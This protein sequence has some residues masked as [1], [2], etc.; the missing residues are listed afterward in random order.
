MKR[1]AA[2]TNQT[3]L[4]E[5]WLSNK[6]IK[7][8]AVSIPK[9]VKADAATKAGDEQP[10]ADT[11]TKLTTLPDGVARG[12]RSNGTISLCK[13]MHRFCVWGVLMLSIT[14][15]FVDL[16]ILDKPLVSVNNL[17]A[18]F[19]NLAHDLLSFPPIPLIKAFGIV[20]PKQWVV[21]PILTREGIVSIIENVIE[22]T[23]GVSKEVTNGQTTTLRSSAH[24]LSRRS[25]MILLK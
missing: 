2:A 14:D 13:I 10:S 1:K 11:P 25:W 23:Y 18:Q 8:P 12:M 6:N 15:H 24:P 20:H 19:A 7:P 9:K 4:S 21:G 22:P 3:K 5:G 16:H 17:L